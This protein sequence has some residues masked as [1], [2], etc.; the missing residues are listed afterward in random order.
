MSPPVSPSPRFA[1]VTGASSGIGAATAA[2]LVRAG[3]EVYGTTRNPTRRDL[4]PKVHWLPLHAHHREGIEAFIADFGELLTNAEILVNNAGSGLFGDFQ[5][6]ASG[7]ISAPLKLMLE[8]PIQLTRAALPSMRER[9]RGVIANTTSLAAVFPLP[10][11]PLY[12]AAKAGLSA[13]TQSLILT[14][15]SSGVA[16]IDF[17]AGD[18]RTLFNDRTERPEHLSREEERVWRILERNLRAAP[19]PTVAARAL[20]R[21]I[22]KGKSRRLR[23]G[24]IFQTRIAPM[25]LRLLP[26][27]WMRWA[28]RSYYHVP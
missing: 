22:L 8:A 4:I 28:L 24:G 16:L 9:G 11:L 27:T 17:Q 12:T 2:E 10:Y 20:T 25:G 3:F 21:A 19:D 26:G 7:A 18:F 14:E 13:F 6:V 23:S 5:T 1:I 15:R